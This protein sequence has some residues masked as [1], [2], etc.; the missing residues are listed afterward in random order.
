MNDAIRSLFCCFSENNGTIPDDVL[1]DAEMRRNISVGAIF[2]SVPVVVVCRNTL[3][4][5]FKL[6]NS[7]AS[8][9]KK[10]FSKPDFSRELGVMAKIKHEIK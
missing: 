3:S 9:I 5:V 2:M 1:T 7:H 4:I 8:Q 10:I 6:I